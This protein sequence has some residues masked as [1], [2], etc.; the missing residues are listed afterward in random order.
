[1]ER[2]ALSLFNDVSA[3]TRILHRGTYVE[4]EV[5]ARIL[6]LGAKFQGSFSDMY[7]DSINCH[8]AISPNPTSLQ[9]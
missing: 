6:Q 3:G 5:K 7:C 9:V 2:P 4:V 8:V 1:M